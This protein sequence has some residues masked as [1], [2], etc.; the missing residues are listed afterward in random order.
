MATGVFFAWYPIK[1]ASQIVAWLPDL[2]AR[3]M[4]NMLRAEIHAAIFAQDTK[5][6]HETARQRSADRQSALG[7]WSRIQNP[8]AGFGE[9]TPPGVKDAIRP[10]L[11]CS[12]T[13][14]PATLAPRLPLFS[15]LTRKATLSLLTRLALTFPP[16]W[17]RGSD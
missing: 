6:G 3:K 7:H 4:T 12:Q 5:Q 13:L 15:P 11:A 17:G 1:D 2:R 10:R 14:A 9:N 16:P 8:A